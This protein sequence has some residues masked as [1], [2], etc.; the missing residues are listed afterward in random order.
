MT[1]PNLIHQA[2]EYDK[3]AI[4]LI[5]QAFEL[6]KKALELKD[7]SAQFE[8]TKKSAGKIQEAR[9]LITKSKELITRYAG[10]QMDE[11]EKQK[12]SYLNHN[13]TGK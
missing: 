13:G 1:D 11:L 12:N 9:E 7:Y 5:R 2:S 6:S 8:L 10:Q 3:K 4:R